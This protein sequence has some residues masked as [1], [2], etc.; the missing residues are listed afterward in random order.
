MPGIVRPS[1]GNPETYSTIEFN[2]FFV[3]SKVGKTGLT[4]LVYFYPPA[5]GLLSRAAEEIGSGFYR[6][7]Y[8]MTAGGGEYG[9]WRAV[10]YTTDGTVD[11]QDVADTCYVAPWLPVQEG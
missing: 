10:A 9:L 8:E 7:Q 4:P 11:Q 1:G 2:F 3:A 5:G 6:V